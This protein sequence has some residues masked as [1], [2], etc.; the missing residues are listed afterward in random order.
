MGL[1]QLKCFIQSLHVFF[2]GRRSAVPSTSPDSLPLKR[3][4]TT[5]TLSRNSPPLL[6]QPIISSHLDMLC[7]QDLPTACRHTVCGGIFNLTA[8][9]Y[10]NTD[11]LTTTLTPDRRPLQGQLSIIVSPYTLKSKSSPTTGTASR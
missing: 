5:T 10:G 4:P 2:L 3:V 9:S 7:G 11:L 6:Q 1:V 8:Q